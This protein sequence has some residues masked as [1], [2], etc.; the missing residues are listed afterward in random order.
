MHTCAC[1]SIVLQPVYVLSTRENSAKD[2]TIVSAKYLHVVNACRLHLSIHNSDVLY[3]VSKTNLQGLPATPCS[4][5]GSLNASDSK[6]K[7]IVANNLESLILVN[8]SVTDVKTDLIGYFEIRNN[9]RIVQFST[10][11]NGSTIIENSTINFINTNIRNIQAVN[12]RFQRVSNI[13]EIYIHTG[14][15]CDEN[16]SFISLSNMRLK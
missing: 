10:R 16:D 3:T 14:S 4:S 8:T 12:S 7:M 9:S 2:I 15:S 13:F 11:V 5:A 1:V 6:F